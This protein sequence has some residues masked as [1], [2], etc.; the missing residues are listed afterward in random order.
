MLEGKSNRAD[1]Q[2]KFARKWKTG[3]PEKMWDLVDRDSKTFVEVKVT[4]KFDEWRR[5]YELSTIPNPGHTSLYLVNPND[6][7]E[8]LVDNP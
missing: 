4:T 7:S 1:I 5:K 2:S 8:L 6:F 3:I